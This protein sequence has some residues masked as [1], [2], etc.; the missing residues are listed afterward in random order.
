S[1][2]LTIAPAETTRQAWR[3]D[4]PGSREYLL[5]ENRQAVGADGGLPGTGLLVWHVDETV[6]DAALPRE[7]ANENELRPGIGLIQADGRPDLRVRANTGD[8]GDPFPG[9]AANHDATD[10]TLP[11]LLGNGGSATS[12]ELR[13]ITVTN[14]TV[15]VDV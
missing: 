13:N 3:V 14:G 11:S 2:T 5:L 9:T 1:R 12:V 6:L 4:L 7:G 10:G 8:A 15:T